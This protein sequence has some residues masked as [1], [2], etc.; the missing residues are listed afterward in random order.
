M[1]VVLHIVYSGL[2]G[3]ASVFFSLA[4]AASDDQ[5]DHAVAFYGIEPLVPDYRERCE[6]LGVTQRFFQRR[7][8]FD[9]VVNGRLFEWMEELQPAAIIVHLPRALGPAVRFRRRYPATCIIGVEHHP[10]V[11]KRIIDWID[12]VRFARQCDHVVY[13]TTVYRREVARRLGRLFA[14]ERSVV[15]P[16]GISTTT[17]HPADAKDP[18]ECRTSGRGILIGMCSRLS[19]Q[20]DILTLLQALSLARR[21]PG[22]EYLTLSLAGD[23]PQRALLEQEAA[24]LDLKEAVHFEGFLA[25]AELVTWFQQL[26]IYVHATLSETM[27]TSVMQ[28]LASGLPCIAS[29][30]SGMDELVPEHVG[31]RVPPGDAPALCAVLIELAEDA[32]CRERLGVAARVFACERLSRERAWADYRALIEGR[33]EELSSNTESSNA[34]K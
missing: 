14:P 16:N 7:P 4:E 29:D 2:G 27:S 31:R 11:L 17:F 30:I 3:I 28:A 24:R 22:S 10:N 9:P 15:I 23:G 20:K 8:H 21:S 6:L 18:T 1:P 34:L 33:Y 13:L 12:S 26:D 19:A 25:E 5:Y 32:D